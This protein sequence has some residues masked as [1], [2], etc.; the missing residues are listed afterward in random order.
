MKENALSDQIIVPIENV[1]MDELSSS[2]QASSPEQV[3]IDTN[4]ELKSSLN[5]VKDQIK[6]IP[7][8]HIL[9]VWESF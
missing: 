2:N 6:I 8:K 5:Q 3:R 9:L 7:K 4:K 1:K